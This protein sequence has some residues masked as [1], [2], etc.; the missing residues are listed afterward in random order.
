MAGTNY[1]GEALPPAIQSEAQADANQVATE[2]RRG[3]RRARPTPDNPPAEAAPTDAKGLG[4]E[5]AWLAHCAVHQTHIL[6]QYLLSLYGNDLN[7]ET[8]IAKA[9]ASRAAMLAEAA[10]WLLAGPAKDI[11]GE[12][13][14]FRGRIMLGE[15][16]P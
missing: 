10:T 13:D 6:C 16:K 2:P 9:C 5:R 3:Q 14:K 7:E 11:Q 12:M 8:F 4:G 15:I 1:G